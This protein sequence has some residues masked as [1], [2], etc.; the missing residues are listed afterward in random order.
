MHAPYY[1]IRHYLVLEPGHFLRW[2]TTNLRVI[3]QFLLFF[4]MVSV[5]MVNL[6]LVPFTV[7]HIRTQM[8]FWN[9]QKKILRRIILSWRWCYNYV[10][11]ISTFFCWKGTNINDCEMDVWLS[12]W[13]KSLKSTY[14][15]RK[16]NSIW[17]SLTLLKMLLLLEL[18]QTL[19]NVSDVC[20]AVLIFRFF[21]ITLDIL[22]LVFVFMFAV[23]LCW[24]FIYV[25]WNVLM[26]CSS[27]LCFLIFLDVYVRICPCDVNFVEDYWPL[28]SEKITLITWL[29][30]IC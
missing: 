14:Y 7:V 3:L 16:I 19:K 23:G 1:G 5:I 4:M 17:L 18:K 2:K 30:S 8:K 10:S 28:I 29:S 13:I 22:V 20:K 25:F 26:F 12:I 21:R 11:W 15:E 24:S 27:S 9:G 6:V